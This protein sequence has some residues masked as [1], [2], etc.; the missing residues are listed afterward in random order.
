MV[1]ILSI[2]AVVVALTGCSTVLG[3]YWGRHY[4][5]KGAFVFKEQAQN[6]HVV[7][8]RP[9]EADATKGAVAVAPS[10]DNYV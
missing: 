9:L 3:F 2:S 1:Y 6:N 7:V 5:S 8:G 4:R 10:G